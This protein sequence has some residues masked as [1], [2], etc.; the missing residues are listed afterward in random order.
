MQLE[1]RLCRKLPPGRVFIS[2]KYC[3]CGEL[4]AG[5]SL[6]DLCKV[7][8]CGDD[9]VRVGLNVLMSTFRC[10]AAGC[11][12]VNRKKQRL[13]GETKCKISRV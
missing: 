3:S 4:H 9:G 11:D 8:G 6:E 2:K 1:H 12:E 5:G 13:A 10:R 7:G